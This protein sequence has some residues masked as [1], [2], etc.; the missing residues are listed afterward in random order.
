MLPE[1]I[2]V[3]ILS[4]L[5]LR[6]AVRT[7]VLSKRWRYQ[8]TCISV[9]NFDA[10]ANKLS[11][12]RSEYIERV[13]SVLAQHRGPN[14]EEFRVCYNLHKAY[15]SHIDEWIEFAL[16]N[17]AHTIELNLSN[18]RSWRSRRRCYTLQREVMGLG[19]AL[20][21]KSLKTLSLK[22]VN[23]GD[24]VMEYFLSN[25]PLLERLFV[26]LNYA[27]KN[28][29][30]V[31]PSLLL[32]HLEVVRCL[33]IEAIEICDTK[34]VS[35]TYDGIPPKILLK[36]AP[37]LVQVSINPNG[38]MWYVQDMFPKFSCCFSRLEILELKILVRRP[39]SF[40]FPGFSSVCFWYVYVCFCLNHGLVF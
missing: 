31:G 11:S 20:G 26:H 39:V 10:K 5:T 24:E 40:K 16:S 21:F 9:L 7:S 25:C 19:P 2:L 4:R 33:S 15:S 8:W 3:S 32:R 12:H 38:A 36:N 37:Q 18:S 30:L 29:K 17:R 23:V 6:E 27:L 1:E 14:V 34:L 35:F 13:S 28:L 22:A